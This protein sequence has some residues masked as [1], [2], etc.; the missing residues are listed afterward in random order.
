MSK[1]KPPT[2]KEQIARLITVVEAQ[3]AQIAALA[4]TLNDVQATVQNIESKQG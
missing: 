3:T 2:Q 1:Q 4:K